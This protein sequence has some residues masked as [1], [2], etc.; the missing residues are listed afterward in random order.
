MRSKARTAA[1]CIAYSL[2]LT[3]AVFGETLDETLEHYLRSRQPTTAED[4]DKNVVSFK[5]PPEAGEEA[6]KLYVIPSLTAI[7][8]MEHLL[9]VHRFNELIDFCDVALAAYPD[10]GAAAYVQGEAYEIKGKTENAIA[11]Y[12]KAVTRTPDFPLPYCM[13]Y[14]LYRHERSDTAEA[15]GSLAK[16]ADILS[17]KRAED[18]WA[19]R[20]KVV[21]DLL[22]HAGYRGNM[23]REFKK[24]LQ[25]AETACR[26]MPEN[27]RAR[28][29]A[30]VMRCNLGLQKGDRELIASGRK[31]LERLSRE[32]KD[33]KVAGFAQH[34]LKNIGTNR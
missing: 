5:L 21:D 14:G 27:E 16:F 19:I 7:A 22:W 8:F 10:F 11:S 18:A 34:T 26:V 31:E 3:N 17:R 24:A 15:E 9:D 28:M 1:L 12:M 13:L 2:F 23:L 20:S 4:A 29:H 6:R 30:A 33:E 25:Y 32:A